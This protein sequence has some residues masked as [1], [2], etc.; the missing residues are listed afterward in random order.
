LEDLIKEI[1]IHLNQYILKEGKINKSFYIV[2]SGKF[3]SLRKEKSGHDKIL[4]QYKEG[5]VFGQTCLVS[6][7][8]SNQSII[9]LVVYG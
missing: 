8:P 6:K 2:E 9:S 3:V 1:P 4:D 7:Q 5:D